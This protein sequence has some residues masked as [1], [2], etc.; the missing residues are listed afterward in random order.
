MR[1]I[2]RYDLSL[3]P[4]QDIEMPAGAAVLAVQAQNN[5]LLIW[6]DVDPD[7]PKVKRR[8]RTYETGDPI[9]DGKEFP[10]YVGTCQVGVGRMALH[11]FTDRTERP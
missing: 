2:S 11:V 3:N 4:V 5:N 10:H 6:A 9:D 7:A 1:M 8:F